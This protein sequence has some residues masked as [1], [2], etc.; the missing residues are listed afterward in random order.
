M[1]HLGLRILIALALA[2]SS[3]AVTNTGEATTNVSNASAGIVS[4]V[5]ALQQDVTNAGEGTLNFFEGGGAITYDN[6]ATA[7]NLTTLVTKVDTLIATV[8]AALAS[9]VLAVPVLTPVCAAAV[10]PTTTGRP[11]LTVV[12]LAQSDFAK[13]TYRATAPGVYRLAEDV[14]F[15]PDLNA[16]GEHWPSCETDAK[17]AAYCAH[18]RVAGAYHLGFFAAL[19]LEGEDVHLDLNGYTLSQSLLHSLKQRFF[20]LVET[21]SAPFLTGQGP[22][23]FGEGVVG[24]RYCSVFGGTLGRSAHHGIHGL[25][26]QDLTIKGVNFRDYEVAAISLNGPQRTLIEDVVAATHSTTVHSRA[27]LSAARFQ[28]MFV[29][30]A[31]ATMTMVGA[32]M[33]QSLI[34]ASEHLQALEDA[35]IASVVAGTP[36]AADHEASTLFGNFETTDGKLVDGNAYGIVIHGRGV[37]VNQFGATQ[38]ETFAEDAQDVTLRNVAIRNVLARVNELVTVA[39]PA[40]GPTEGKPMVGIAGAVLRID[41]QNTDP[42]MGTGTFALDALHT[43]RFEYAA[44]LTTVNATVPASVRAALTGTLRID[45]ALVQAYTNGD[46]A[47]VAAQLATYTKIC[48]ADSMFH[49]QKGVIGLF[50][51]K[52]ARLHLANVTVGRVRNH[53]PLGSEACGPYLTSQWP[54][55]VGYTGSQSY[56]VVVTTSR[57]VAAEGLS[58][59][60]V[61]S[62]HATAYGAAFF[63]DVD[64]ACLTETTIGAVGTGTNMGPNDPPLSLPLVL[65][66]AVGGFGGITTS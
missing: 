16:D 20:A 44:L 49:A 41:E 18:G 46:D 19:T 48:N 40:G 61:W 31:T 9:A 14:V 45:E 37:L 29:A 7:C 23:D 65:G 62:A 13:G 4:A 22:G 6:G 47:N 59:D 17:A 57:D 1:H 12:E 54:G 21:G 56:G 43:L 38:S 5:R 32:T 2:L 26:N 30:M 11:L 52:T 60:G 34:G 66:E 51:Q 58:V 55:H 42:F 28:Q 8:S 64:E 63:N 27:T 3:R 15:E 53:G 33:P 39:M 10:L 50:V 24:C 35:F 25:R 36:L